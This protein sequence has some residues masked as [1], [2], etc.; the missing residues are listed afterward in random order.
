MFQ[1]A[2]WIFNLREPIW[3]LPDTPSPSGGA[4][5]SGRCGQ[6]SQSASQ[7]RSGRWCW[8]RR[9]SAGARGQTAPL[10]T[11]RQ[12]D[13][14]VFACTCIFTNLSASPWP[15][16]GDDFLH[17]CFAPWSLWPG[18]KSVRWPWQ[19]GAASSKRG[20]CWRKDQLRHG[21][22]VRRRRDE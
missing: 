19:S 11:E 16:A 6:C 8:P 22:T 14:R 18:Q 9:C 15:P 1:T 2:V 3:S 5:C 21:E 4:A 20:R 17:R 12:Q 7:T 13:R 10:N